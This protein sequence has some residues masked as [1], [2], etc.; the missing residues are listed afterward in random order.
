[1]RTK[2]VLIA[3][4][5][6]CAFSSAGTAGASGRLPC[7]ASMSNASPTVNS[8]THVLVRTAA[9]A[10]VSTVAHYKTTQT[11]HSG[12]ADGGGRADIAYR[13]S[14]ATKGY[15]VVVDV[16]VSKSGLRNSCSTSFTPR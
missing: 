1:M 8:T 12:T 14:H 11:A 5:T 4:T 9:A 13:I 10:A 3:A 6:A 2:L 16:T 7:A 15:R